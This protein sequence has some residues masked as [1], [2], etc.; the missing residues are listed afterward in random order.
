[1]RPLPALFV[2]AVL[3]AGAI[4]AVVKLSPASATWASRSDWEHRHPGPDSGRVAIIL[5]ALGKT[6]P[7]VCEMIGDQI[8]NFWNSGERSG[9]GRLASVTPAQQ[10]AKDS[11]GGH[12]ADP[13][14]INRLVAELSGPNACVRRVASKMLGRSAITTARLT[15]LLS[16]ASPVVREAAALAAG[17]GDHHDMRLAL[18]QTLGDRVAAVA[19]MSAWALGE[20]DD[21]ESLPVLLSA[22]KSDELRVRMAA[23]WALGQLDDARAVPTV[24]PALHAADPN[25]RAMAAEVL[26][27]LKSE[28]TREA[29][30]VALSRDT[31]ARVRAAAANALGEIS[32]ASSLTPL[33]NALE[34]ADIEVR[35][36][37]ASALGD[38]DE[39]HTAPPGLVRALLSTD[40]ELRHLAAEALCS[41]AD[42][43]TTSALLGL[44]SNPDADLRKNAIEALGNIGSPSAISGL[45]KALTDKDP[46]VRRAAAEALGEIKDK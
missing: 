9:V 43:S 5:D 32:S 24:L 25:L 4:G 35:R 13:R 17:Q 45:T 41:I 1:M 16:D 46:Q 40:P 15:S 12:V 22:A 29:L 38:L 39:S 18:E 3:G 10:A 26:G 21:V 28:G 30:E 7:I 42:P 6:D 27:E 23:I 14:A 20:L 33:G 19:A 34:D 11:I 2:S 44:L 36:A 31:D 37:A 8:G